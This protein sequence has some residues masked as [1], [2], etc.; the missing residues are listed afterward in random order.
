KAP[1]EVNIIDCV[2]EDALK[3]R[4]TRITE[5]IQSGRIKKANSLLG[6]DYTI[7][8]EVIHGKGKGHSMGFPTANIALNKE[9]I[10]PK[11]GVYAGYV[12]LEDKPYKAMINIGHNPTFNY[13][14]ELS[15]EAYILDF[16]QDI[17]TSKVKVAFVYYLRDE[18][19]F[20]SKEA[21][22]EQL[23]KDVVTTDEVVQL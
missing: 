15:I 10:V 11:Q 2:A 21:L 7:D 6:Y 4:S 18:E 13:R 12:E 23:K 8:G 9:Y 17:Y 22:I 5:L 1:F 14:N 3:I 20:E 16:D 19:K